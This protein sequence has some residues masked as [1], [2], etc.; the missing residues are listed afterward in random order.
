MKQIRVNI[1]TLVN[2][3]KIR[4]ETRNGREVV[5]VPS[6]TLPD[7][8]VMNGIM[9]PAAEIEKSY[10]SLERTPAPLGHPVNESGEFLSAFDPE[11]INTFYIGAWNEKVQR[12]NG[13]V[14]ID[15]VIDVSFAGACEGGRRVLNAIEEGKP[16]HTSTGLMAEMEDVDDPDGALN[17]KR[18]A[19]NI[20]FDHDAIL[21]DQSGAATPE[22]GVGMLV[23]GAQVEVVNSTLEEAFD[24]EIEYS[25]LSLA[26]AMR[27]KDDLS[28]A[29]RIIEA[30]KAMVAGPPQ[31]ET[32]ANEADMTVTK[33]Q[34]DALSEKVANLSDSI[35]KLDI[36]AAVAAAIKPLTDTVTNLQTQANASIEA[37]KSAL[38]EKVVKAN[39]LN[40]EDAKAATIPTLKAL[41][42]T[43][44]VEDPA[45]MAGFYRNQS[46]DQFDWSKALP[47]E[48]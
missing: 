2:A 38:V 27:R 18:I 36:G 11:A 48:A 23:N 4:K 42:N 41:A 46:K 33:E 14:F 25:A 40:E 8:V 37:E 47:K 7:D 13:R 24:R 1:T 12:V 21:L 29:Q 39:L 20:V 28:L 10:A 17:Y 19:R 3:G 35:A 44:K 5:V 30:V 22:Q 16:I 31:T 15:K 34:F 26:S 9:Y 43:I 45:P 6:A 32:A